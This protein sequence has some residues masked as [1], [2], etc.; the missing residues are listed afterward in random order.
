MSSARD[1]YPEYFAERL[2]DWL[3]AIHRELDAGPAGE[4]G[5]GAL[6]ALLAAIGSQAAVARRSQDR[7]WDD[8][9]VELADDWAVPYIADLVATRLVS[10][11]NLRARRADVAKTIYYR[12]RKGTP[13]VLEQLIADMSGWE[14]KL[15][16]QFRC[17]GRMRHGLDGPARRGRITGT[18]EGGWADLR[19]VR[20]ARLAGDPF[21]EFHFTPETRRPT[22]PR[23]RLGLRGIAVLGFHLYRLRSVE[24]I[25]VQPRRVNNLPGARDGYTFDPSGRDVPLFAAPNSERDWAAWQ[26]AAEWALPRPIDCRLLNEAVFEIGAEELAWVLSAAPI[27][28]LPLRQA[29]AAD[30]R[31][32]AG[33]RF[34]GAGALTR[35]LAGL[36]QAATLTAPGVQAGLLLQALVADCGSAALLADASGLTS[37]QRAPALALFPLG[38]AALPR[39][40]T[41]GADL[42]AWPQ[43]LLAGVDLFVDPA[44]GRFVFDPG[45]TSPLD[46]RVRYRGGQ[47]GPIGAGA[48]PREIDPTP[49][50]VHWQ[51]RSSTPGVPSSG[52]VEIDDSSS[53]VAPPDQ[54]AITELTLRAAEGQRPYVELNAPWQLGAAGANRRLV[55]DGLWIGA[56]GAAALVVAGDWARVELRH[57]TL[58]PGGL[59]AMGALLPPCELVV[60]GSI[61]TLAIERSIL[62]ALRLQGAAA[63]VDRIELRDSIVDA[64][65]SIGLRAPRAEAVFERCTVIGA[66]IGAL[67]VDVERLSASDT[68]IAGRADATDVQSGCFRY[69]ARAPR[70][71]VPHPYASHVIDDL[72]RLFASRRFGD[73]AY[74]TL[75]PHAG[76]AL[77]AGSEKGSEIGAFCSEIG[78]IKLASLRSKVEEYMPF[79]RLPATLL[80]N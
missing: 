20:G 23:G 10:S 43:P 35:V 4:G 28:S 60:T 26:S 69:S 73:P 32:L 45:A 38:G 57:V 52:I 74:A 7:L 58:D 21:D 64:T 80:E 49:A 59:D 70:S 44:R 12:R 56:R 61:D 39:E 16:E 55:I 14:G 31:K 78:P 13:A 6:R 54:A 17:L 75:Q 77:H 63:G 29:A 50:T 67:V 22:A 1:R 65:R 36:P 19:S 40:R 66:A 72:E 18:P 42:A 34:D 27:A 9:F 68:L 51:Q 46:L 37:Q 41:R 5:G 71:R 24:W 3:P 33:Q 48:L 25:G 11:L 53:F 2:W 79:G 8:M 47:A 15:V 30:L 62:P 76:Q